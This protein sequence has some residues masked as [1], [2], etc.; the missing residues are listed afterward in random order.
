MYNSIWYHNLIQPALTPPAW[1]F[2]VAWTILYLL[3]AISFVI[4]LRTKSKY[5]KIQG[6]VM[7]FTQLALNFCW[8]PAFFYFKSPEF[9]L[10]IILF[11]DI[12]V[13]LTIIEFFKV[14][15][16]SAGILVP[17]FL[18]IIFATYLNIGYVV[19]N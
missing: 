17:Y 10:V 6:A 11:L 1:V 3:M 16:Y 7:F 2:S 8:S 15:K 13:L 12:A 18:W 19:L 5:D 4:F 9:A 14:S